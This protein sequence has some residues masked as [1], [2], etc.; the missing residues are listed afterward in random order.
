MRRTRLVLLS[1]LAVG[2]IGGMTSGAAQAGTSLFCPN[3]YEGDYR[4][5]DADGGTC[6]SAHFSTL[7]AV[8]FVAAGY[9]YEHCALGKA[10]SDGGGANT[11]NTACSTNYWATTSCYASHSGYAKGINREPSRHTYQ[12]ATWW[13]TSCP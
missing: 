5:V 6:V 4:L 1:L 13:G 10:N 2:A 9:G 8:R 3:T 12:G 7:R 11:T